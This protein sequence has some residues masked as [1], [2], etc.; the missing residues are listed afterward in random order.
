M[1]TAFHAYRTVEVRFMPVLVSLTREKRNQSDSR[2][3]R[4]QTPTARYQPGRPGGAIVRPQRTTG[5]SYRT[6]IRNQAADANLPE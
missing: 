5:E 4:D 2:F 1:I 6:N 3:L